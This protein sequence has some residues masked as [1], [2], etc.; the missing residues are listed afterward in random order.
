MARPKKNVK[1]KGGALGDV[2]AVEIRGANGSHTLV[3]TFTS[4][5]QKLNTDPG[6]MIYLKGNVSK[7]EL[8]VA[9]LGTGF[10][11]LFSGQ[12]M[13][14]STYTGNENCSE[15][16]P[17]MVALSMDMPAD[18]IQLVIPEGQKYR[19]SRGSFLASTSN[20]EMKATVKAKGIFGIGQEEGFVL[21]ILEVPVGTGEG[22]VWLS[23]F[24]MFEKHALLPQEEMI[25]D[26]GVF[27]AVDN[28][29]D[30]EIVK[31][32]RTI[33]GSLFS[34]EGFGMKFVGPCTLYSQSKNF[35]DFS[36]MVAQRAG[37]DKAQPVIEFNQS[38]GSKK[39]SIKK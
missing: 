3:V 1:K 38:G 9:G 6:S 14:L 8:S 29:L 23:S 27:L 31:L 11:R 4:P 17:G 2:P 5:T 37:V 24:G 25:V 20:V 39:K 7:A 35:N 10:A 28:D 12:S 19:I 34:G 36:I 32:G 16:S 15:T 26:N 33:L 21:P 30:Y 13:F 22:I 18:I